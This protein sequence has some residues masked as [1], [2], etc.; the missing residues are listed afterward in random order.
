MTPQSCFGKRRHILIL[1]LFT[2]GSILLGCKDSNTITGTRQEVTPTPTPVSEVTPTPTLMSF[3]GAWTGTFSSFD[4]DP[5]DCKPNVPAQAVFTQEGSR[6][7]GTLDAAEAG[8]GTS[9]VV[10]HATLTE[11]GFQGTIVSS[12]GGYRFH[13]GSTVS[14]RLSG[15]ALRVTLQD[16]SHSYVPGGTMQLH[17]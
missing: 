5:D 13:A 14:G 6:V 8:C 15:S 12:A 1:G 17:R 3:A 2:I 10:V 9:Q 16:S 11:A 7:D 4:L